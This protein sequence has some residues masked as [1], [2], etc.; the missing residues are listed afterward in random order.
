MRPFALGQHLGLLTQAGGRFSQIVGTAEIDPD[1]VPEILAQL[2]DIAPDD[3]YVGL[4][5][6]FADGD[7]PGNRID[8]PLFVLPI[9]IVQVHACLHPL[10]IFD[11]I[12]PICY[13]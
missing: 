13:N 7:F 12:F 8:P 4:K 5:R 1:F 2:D 10:Y 3:A 9:L 6:F 11:N